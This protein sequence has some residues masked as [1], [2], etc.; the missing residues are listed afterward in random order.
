M[1]MR[2]VP[3]FLVLALFAACGKPKPAASATD[4]T[5]TPDASTATPTA[6]DAKAQAEAKQLGHELFD[7]VDRI[8]NYSSAH[9]GEFPRNFPAM[10]IDSLT[11][12]TVRRVTFHGKVPTVTVAFRQT[13]G[14]AVTAC[15][16]TNKVLEDSML[17]GGPYTVSCALADGT[18]Q[19]FTVGG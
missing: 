18:P 10:G 5:A 2:P 12:T 6:N 14:H 9:F 3:L 15:S 19:D 4:S 17:N 13:E 7:L 1:T 11:R 16:G 8:M